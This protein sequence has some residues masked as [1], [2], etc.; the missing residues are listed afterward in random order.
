LIEKNRVHNLFDAQ[1]TSNQQSYGFFIGAD[2]S[3][4][5]ANRVIN[6]LIYNMN[7]NGP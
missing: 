3:A 1:L 6:N 5:K 2:P 7:G 4:A